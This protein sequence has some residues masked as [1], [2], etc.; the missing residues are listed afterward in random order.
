[1]T[2]ENVVTVT[3]LEN[4]PELRAYFRKKYDDN[5]R[6]TSRIAPQSDTLSTS[7]VGPHIRRKRKLLD[8]FR[9]LLSRMD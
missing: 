3:M 9:N 5:I 2:E 6:I 4:D 1:M 8:L 7:T